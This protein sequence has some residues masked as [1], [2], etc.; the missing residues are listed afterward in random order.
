MKVC[1]VF[2]FCIMFYPLYADTQDIPLPNLKKSQN[3]SKLH[4]NI[5]LQFSKN[6]K[7]SILR[8]QGII[9]NKMASHVFKDSKEVCYML[10]FSALKDLQTQALLLGGTK[11]GNIESYL[12][13]SPKRIVKHFQ[14]KSGAMFS[15]VTLR[16][17][18]R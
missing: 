9:A 16:A 18:V 10:F 14:C 6:P 15:I 2:L 7:R 13:N 8:K 17:D 3:I 4:K 1:F 12:N 5:T 11:V